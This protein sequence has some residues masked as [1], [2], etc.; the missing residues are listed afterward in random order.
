MKSI[1][2]RLLGSCV[3]LLLNL[4]TNCASPSQLEQAIAFSYEGQF[5]KALL[6]HQLAI[7]QNPLDAEAYRRMGDTYLSMERFQL[8][9]SNYQK[10]IELEPKNEI[11]HQKLGQTYVEMDRLHKA[12]DVYQ[13]FLAIN[14]E[15]FAVNK[16]LGRAY[17]LSGDYDNSIRFSK[18]AVSLT[19]NIAEHWRLGFRMALAYLLLGEYETASVIYSEIKKLGEIRYFGRPFEAIDAL[20]TQVRT[21]HRAEE[22]KRILRQTF[23]YSYSD[24][25]SLQREDIPIEPYHALTVKPT[26]IKRVQLRYPKLAPVAQSQGTVIVKALIN[27]DGNVESAEV[28]VDCDAWLNE[29]ALAAAYQYKFSPGKTVQGPVRVWMLLPFTFRIRYH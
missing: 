19:N 1:V 5:N 27:N 29:A 28:L 11:A 4:V 14:S 17:L 21:G 6:A 20:E 24:S 10:A 25:T 2:Q 23:G 16:D 8:A 13:D 7:E 15:S 26:V 22:A 18:K 12:I 3:I 9:I